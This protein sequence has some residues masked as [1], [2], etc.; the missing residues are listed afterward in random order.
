[1]VM[2][3][4]GVVA[5]E[6]YPVRPLLKSLYSDDVLPIVHMSIFHCC[7]QVHYEYLIDRFMMFVDNDIKMIEIILNARNFQ[8]TTLKRL[9]FVIIFHQHTIYEKFG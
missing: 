7:F 4:G 8:K 3:R 2:I 9:D 1:M 6:Y 5:V